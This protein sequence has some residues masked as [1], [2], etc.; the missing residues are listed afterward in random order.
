MIN[1]DAIQNL[2]GLL[3]LIEADR[4][5]LNLNDFFFDRTESKWLSGLLE[6]VILLLFLVVTENL[7]VH[8]TI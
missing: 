5:S 7:Q 8:S 3:N 4:K 6:V 1:G 2:S